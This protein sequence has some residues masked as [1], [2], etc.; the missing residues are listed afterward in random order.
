MNFEVAE[1]LKFWTEKIIEIDPTEKGK[2][3][4]RSNT[5]ENARGDQRAALEQEG[6][7][8]DGKGKRHVGHKFGDCLEIAE[9]LLVPSSTREFD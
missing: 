6:G 2:A 4:P 3:K 9:T 5:R 1:L 8:I 7:T